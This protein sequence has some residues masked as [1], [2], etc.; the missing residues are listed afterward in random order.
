[1]GKKIID[2]I[3]PPIKQK[4][5]KQNTQQSNP[6]NE[7]PKKKPKIGERQMED[8]EY[9]VLE[10]NLN[11]PN[12]QNE[13]KSPW[14]EEEKAD[15]SDTTLSQTEQN[16]TSL[17]EQITL[18]YQAF[19]EITQEIE[20]DKIHTDVHFIDSEIETITSQ[21]TIAETSLPIEPE[22]T[23]TYH[24]A[25]DNLSQI[26]LTDTDTYPFENPIYH[27]SQLF[28]N[29]HLTYFEQ[30]NSMNENLLSSVTTDSAKKSTQNQV[31]DPENQSFV[32]TKDTN[33]EE[34]TST[35]S[36]K[37]ITLFSHTNMQTETSS[38]IDYQPTDIQKITE[39]V[40]LQAPAMNALLKNA[41]R[42]IMQ[43]RGIH[44]ITPETL[45]LIKDDLSLV[46]E[47]SGSNLSTMVGDVLH[48]K[49][50]VNDKVNQRRDKI[51]EYKN[52][53]TQKISQLLAQVRYLEGEVGKLDNIIY[54]DL[55]ELA[56][57]N[58]TLD[59]YQMLLTSISEQ[60]F[61]FE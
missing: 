23:N 20:Q 47:A 22:T 12:A 49:K 54:T 57:L 13:N 42:T 6:E 56:K 15:N 51:N 9:E 17:D 61:N 52:E 58:K 60:K 26:P 24:I 14:V 3:A 43:R 29:S 4:V 50:V 27:T 10:S 36:K 7:P 11:T 53:L 21:Y 1:M 5:L 2:F 44:E 25:G 8:A 46:L 18:P 30:D 40:T 28:E 16:S 35:D 19:E 38:P 55:E 41:V 48:I 45:P 37:S 33:P 39:E 34:S 59:T 32:Q 31:Q